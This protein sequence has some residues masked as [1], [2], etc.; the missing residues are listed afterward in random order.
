MSTKQISEPAEPLTVE[1]GNCGAELVATPKYLQ[2]TRTE[3]MQF[4]GFSGFCPTCQVTVKAE[5]EPP[6]VGQTVEFIRGAA[7]WI[8]K[9]GI[10]IETLPRQ[11]V[12]D[13]PS[14]REVVSIP[15]V[16]VIKPARGP[17]ELSTAQYEF[18]HGR[19]PRGTGQWAFFF[20]GQTEPYWGYGSYAK[21]S[22]DAR[23]LAVANGFTRIEVGS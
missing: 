23:K 1:C 18:A 14:G 11:V 8:G 4:L 22:G 21:C 10:V 17:V 16:K 2:A 5:L 3:P 7:E 20:D 12:V 6:E 15:A 19:K 13:F 9:R